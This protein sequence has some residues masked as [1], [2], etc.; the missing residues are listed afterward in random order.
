M[1]YSEYT[2]IYV[3]SSFSCATSSLNNV[4]KIILQNNRK[5]TRDS[6]NI[7][8]LSTFLD[9]YFLIIVADFVFL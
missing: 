9:F 3:N 5:W 4:D 2:L 8:D 7:Q 6:S 1:Q